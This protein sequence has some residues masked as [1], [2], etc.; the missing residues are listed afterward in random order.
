M[1][2]PVLAC[3]QHLLHAGGRTDFA[4]LTQLLHDWPLQ[5]ALI[6]GSWKQEVDDGNVTRCSHA[7]RHCVDMAKRLKRFKGLHFS[8][9][10]LGPVSELGGL[11]A[12]WVAA[13]LAYYDLVTPSKIAALDKAE[14]A[15]KAAEIA[16]TAGEHFKHPLFHKDLAELK[17]LGKPP[18][19]VDV[20]VFAAVVL[21]GA[22]EADAEVDWKTCQ[23]LGDPCSAIDRLRNLT[24]SDVQQPNLHRAKE[25]ANQHFFSADVMIK[26]SAAAASLTVWVKGFIRD[27][28]ATEP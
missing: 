28:E 17:C 27:A 21:A 13:A 12:T 26:K 20:V 2:K 15:I 22:V 16:K 23:K 19:G 10:T 18:A 4:S 8:A 6:Q 9:E 14:A 1:V 3:V 25:L 5:E 24:R 11:L 7:A